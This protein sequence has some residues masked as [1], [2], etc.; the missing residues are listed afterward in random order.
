MGSLGTYVKYTAFVNFF[1]NL[2]FFQTFTDQTSP[3][4][5]MLDG[6]D[7]ALQRKEVPYIGVVMLGENVSG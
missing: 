5:I 3:P 6:S 7:D 4:N 2:F 1:L